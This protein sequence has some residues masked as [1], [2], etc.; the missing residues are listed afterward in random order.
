MLFSLD[1]RW[2]WQAIL[3]EIATVNCPSWN[4]M[5]IFEKLRCKNRSSRSR[6][7]EGGRAES[8]VS[9]EI[10]S[11]LGLLREEKK[12]GSVY[13]YSISTYYNQKINKNQLL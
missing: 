9:A 11:Q 4:K 3:G 12:A 10:P 1:G 6:V 7:L 5:L 13:S 8:D 2:Q